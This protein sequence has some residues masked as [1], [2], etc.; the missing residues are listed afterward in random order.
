[1]YGV[2]RSLLKGKPRDC[3]AFENFPLAQE[4]PC[5]D[6]WL[7]LNECTNLKFQNITFM[8]P[9]IN[10]LRVQYHGIFNIEF[11]L[12]LLN[13]HP[14]THYLY[15]IL[16]TANSTNTSPSSSACTW[17]APALVSGLSSIVSYLI[18]MSCRTRLLYARFHSHNPH[19]CATKMVFVYAFTQ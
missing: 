6:F 15:S 17:L 19:R 1:M 2:S 10:H 7:E 13:Y 9:K 14:H 16:K 8:D 11:L 4:E 3:G 5:I 12:S 18:T